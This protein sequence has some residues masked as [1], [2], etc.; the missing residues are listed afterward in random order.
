[1]KYKI[2][3]D[4]RGKYTLFVQVSHGGKAVWKG[5]GTYNHG[6]SFEEVAEAI[7]EVHKKAG[8]QADSAKDYAS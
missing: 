4:D 5:G 8:I 2:Q 3:G 6:A 1:M 7:D